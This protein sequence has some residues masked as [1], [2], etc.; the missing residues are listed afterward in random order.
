MREILVLLLSK[1]KQCSCHYGQF[2]FGA[3]KN[4]KPSS[5]VNPV[6]S[7]MSGYPPSPAGWGRSPASVQP[8]TPTS[9]PE[10]SQSPLNTIDSAQTATG[11]ANLDINSTSSVS[12]S[13]FPQSSSYNIAS[14][15]S[16]SSSSFLTNPG[17]DINGGMGGQQGKLSILLTQG[18]HGPDTGA[19][20]A[21]SLGPAATSNRRAVAAAA[22]ARRASGQI[23]STTSSSSAR[24][25]KGGNN[26]NS[27][28]NP[29]S[30][31]NHI[32]GA[33]AL[34]SPLDDHLH[35]SPTEGPGQSPPEKPQSTVNEDCD[36][37]TTSTSASTTSASGGG[38]NAG[39]SNTNSGSGG[40]ATI[41]PSDGSS[42]VGGQ[43]SGMGGPSSSGGGSLGGGGGGGS[44]SNDKSI[45]IL[46]HLLSKE[47]DEEMLESNL[48]SPTFSSSSTGG[49]GVEFAA[50]LG[51]SGSGNKNEAEPKKTHALLKVIFIFFF[52]Q[53][54]DIFKNFF[55]KC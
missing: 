45:N 39:S 9:A 16:P 17:L 40:G 32:S 34:K 48:S 51:N 26:N 38:G 49:Q 8:A 20:E 44:N 37:D 22:R 7:D 24:L 5:L 13:G 43:P 42:G 47:D 2:Y 28:N 12:S 6:C 30:S 19:G 29:V 54:C 18:S 31:T 4:V 35:Q 23:G 11:L 50:A 41:T 3:N 36:M 14:T 21:A 25:P 46:K 52:W 10:Y 27:S 55:K 53:G 33:N 15:P 1:W